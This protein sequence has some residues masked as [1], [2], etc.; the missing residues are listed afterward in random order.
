MATEGPGN[1]ALC[2]HFS[3]CVLDEASLRLS[4]G[5]QVVELE[6]KPLEVLRYLLRHAGEVVTKDE[7]LEAVWPGRILSDTVLA[8]AVSRLRDVLGEAGAQAIKTVHGY[9]YRLVAEVRVEQQAA[10][11]PASLGLKPGDAPPL[12]P[13][14][15]LEQHLQSGGRGEVWRVRHAKTGETR[16]F[17]FAL[18]EAAL[19]S[20][21]REITLN[22]L[23][24]STLGADAAIVPLLDWNLQDTPFFIELAWQPLGSLADWAAARGGL[25]QVPAALRLELAAQIAEAVSAAHGAGVLHKDLKPGNVLLAG[26]A[27]APRVLLTDFGS[28]A[29]IEQSQLDAFGITRLGLTQALGSSTDASGTPLYFAPEV[30]AGQP[31]TVR[32]DNYA[33]GVLLYQLVVG[34]FKRPLS[35]GWERDIEDALLRED[36]A[37]AADGNPQH[38]LGD[39]EELARRLRTLEARRA[40]R[41]RRAEAEAQAER[42]RAEAAQARAENEQ[43]RSRRR[44][45]W[46]AIAALAGGLVVSLGMYRRAQQA[47]QQAIAAARTAEAVSGFLADDLLAAADPARVDVRTLT[48]KTLLDAAETRVG[49][50]FA[51]D[52]FAE[53]KVRRALSASY[54]SLGQT[55]RAFAQIRQSWALLPPLLD[56]R[57]P[58]L[59]DVAAELAQLPDAAKPEDLA[60]WGEVL[61][62][63]RQAPGAEDPRTLAV[64]A[65]IAGVHFDH[66][67]FDDCFALLDRSLEAVRRLSP[68]EPSLEV[69]L[70]YL[71][72]RAN[73]SVDRYPAAIG[74]ARAALTLLREPGQVE[75]AERKI[76]LQ[77]QY[78][79]RALRYY[80]QLN[81]AE[82]VLQEAAATTLRNARD[83]SEA[84]TELRWELLGVH[85]M[86]KRWA[87]TEREAEQLDRDVRAQFTL[88]GDTRTPLFLLGARAQVADGEGRLRDAEA[89]WREQL[90]G[91]EALQRDP[92]RRLPR[93]RTSIVVSKLGLARTLIHAGRSGEAQAL[94]DGLSAED[95]ATT[96][97]V[98]LN[99]VSLLRVRAELAQARGEREAA[100][101]NYAAA[102]EALARLCAPEHPWIAEF[103]AALARLDAAKAAA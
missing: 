35:P 72:S 81:E 28:G 25:A 38:R 95:L 5:G 62:R 48:V 58:Q 75:Q 90:A 57:A 7:V 59:A 39:A 17:K 8:K 6:R 96:D 63:L 68:R 103:D 37:L 67:N 51:D 34:D 16:V 76:A 91:F 79:G 77:L 94:L 30:L 88:T 82:R 78:L 42:S 85:L 99:R 98:P 20:L 52:P 40:E 65:F 41:S 23:L 83:D 45:Q 11:R 15:L 87:E 66:G 2:W 71:R 93:D 12:R 14:W 43:L 89:L 13:N 102:R 31:H 97:T 26:A 24:R 44:W 64:A 55:E 27:E 32:S 19:V 60:R 3:G 56:A 101:A 53:A 9:G 46:L 18:D 61:E 50:R 54:Y 92:Q 100:R 36:I 84:V 74:D 21:K 47:Q 1:A 73:I 22:R 86:Q 70:L 69:Q 49:R 29:V 80:G 4:V 10:P 33:L